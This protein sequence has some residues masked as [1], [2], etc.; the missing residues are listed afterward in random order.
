[1][2]FSLKKTKAQALGEYAIT[3]A[4]VITVMITM[5]IF[6]RRALQARIKDARD[7]MVDM[8]RSA[9]DSPIPYAYEPYYANQISETTREINDQ[10]KLLPGGSKGRTGIFIKNFDETTTSNAESIQAPPKDAY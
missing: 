9:S 2:I 3:I 8:A 4:L 7:T 10:T 6:L 5:T 1:M